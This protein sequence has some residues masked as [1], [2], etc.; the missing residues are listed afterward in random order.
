MRFA[1]LALLL[2]LAG[3]APDRSPQGVCERESWNDPDV[4]LLMDKIAGNPTQ[5]EQ[6]QP[7]LDRDRKRA[8]VR[9]LQA[10]GILAPGGVEAVIP[11][12]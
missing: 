6:W 4:K 9:C 7:D 12:K 1:G 8:T 2:A 10:A 11:P 5:Q 3:C